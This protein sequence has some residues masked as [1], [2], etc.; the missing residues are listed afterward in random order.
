MD[1]PEAEDEAIDCEEMARQITFVLGNNVYLGL[2]C[3]LKAV[4]GELS[5]QPEVREDLRREAIE[6]LDNG[7]IELKNTKKLSKDQQFHF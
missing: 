1:L 4:I 6:F 7:K 3:L 2:Q 5:N